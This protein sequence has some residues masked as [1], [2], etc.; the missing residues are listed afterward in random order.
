[1]I[2]TNRSLSVIVATAAG[3]TGARF[4]LVTILIRVSDGFDAISYSGLGVGTSF[5]GCR[6]IR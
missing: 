6:N 4:S 3:A 2:A 5:F 1:L